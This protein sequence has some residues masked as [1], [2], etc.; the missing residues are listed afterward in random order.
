MKWL[1][2]M[3]LVVAGGVAHCEDAR[4]APDIIGVLERSQQK[5][6]D[7]MIPADGDSPRART[8][9]GSFEKLLRH[10]DNPELMKVQLRVVRGDVV[11]ETLQG[12]IVVANVSLADLPEGERLFILAHELG[13][14]ALRHWPQMELLY[15]KWIPGAVEQRH[16]DAVAE[17]L[18]RDAS[19]LAHRQEYEADAFALATLR[20][21]GL[22]DQDAVSA[23]MDLGWRDDTATH[24]GTRKRLAALRR[25]S[26]G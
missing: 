14:A 19:M 7:A 13:H 10:L 24:P 11:G 1:L 2:V 23:F 20:A 9:R 22:N 3:C 21:L 5:Q 26:G 15:A 17:R 16:T 4:P 25:R 6:L 18:G 12:R 8:V